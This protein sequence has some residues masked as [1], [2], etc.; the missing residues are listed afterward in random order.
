MQMGGQEEY[1]QLVTAPGLLSTLA[2][3]SAAQPQPKSE[4]F[5]SP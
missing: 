2:S 5:L 3:H 4:A 1:V